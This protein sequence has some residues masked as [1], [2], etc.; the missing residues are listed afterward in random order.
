MSSKEKVENVDYKYK[1]KIVNLRVD[2]VL[3]PNGNK[4]EREI[5]EH[6]GGVTVL[7][8]TEDNKILMVEQYRNPVDEFLLELP[9]GKLEKGEDPYDCAYRE[10]IEETGYQA[11]NMEK[12]FSFH[13]TPGFCDEFLHLYIARDLKEVGVDPD[14]DEIIVNHQIEKSDIL[15]MIESGKIKDGKSVI[16]LLYFL[17]GVN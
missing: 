1:G 17:A 2:Q 11:G 6:P 10:L 13:T 14:D 16:G 7:A 8:I 4:A 12:L 9:A 15:K 3:T 5:V